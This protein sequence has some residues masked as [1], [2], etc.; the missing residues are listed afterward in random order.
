MARTDPGSAPT[1]TSTAPVEPAVT[2]S[3]DLTAAEG[4]DALVPAEVMAQSLS[5][6][7]HARR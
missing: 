6:Y 3:V 1:T 5:E 4:S 7:V 2:P